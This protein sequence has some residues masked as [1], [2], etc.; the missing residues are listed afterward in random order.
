MTE[1]SQ[2]QMPCALRRMFAIIAVFF[3]YADIRKLWDNHFESKAEDYHRNFGDDSY[4]IQLVL[5]DVVDI[6][7]SMGKDIKDFVLPHLDESGMLFTLHIIL[8]KMLKVFGS[9][10]ID[11]CKRTLI[12]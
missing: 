5:R 8:I 12:W 11:I 10:G 3:K 9:I 4:V 6:V 7:R 2:F 1:A